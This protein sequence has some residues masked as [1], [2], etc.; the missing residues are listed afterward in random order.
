MII[1]QD[2]NIFQAPID[3]LVHQANCFCTFGSGIA[4]VIRENFP[5]A[6]AADCETKKGDKNKLGTYSVGIIRNPS[7]FKYIVNLYGQYDT[8]ATTRKTN[9]EALY[10][11]MELIRDNILNKKVNLDIGFPYKIGCGFG[12]GDW[13]VVRAMILSVFDSYPNKVMICKKPED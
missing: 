12:G 11:G 9:Y 2:I 8:S 3:V 7:T 13:N 5:E 1:E 4:K 6:Y 10:S